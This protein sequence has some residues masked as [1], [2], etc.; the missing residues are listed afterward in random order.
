MK[1]PPSPVQESAQAM[2]AAGR[3]FHQRGWV[4]AT[5][6]NFSARLGAESMLVTASGWHKGE[7]DQDAFLISDLNG[8]PQDSGRKASYETLLHCQLYRHDPD[9]GSVLHT[10]SIAN[11]VLSRRH[12]SIVLTG[13]ELLKLLPGI[14]THD[15]TVEV[16]VFGNDQD[17][18]RLA[19]TVDQWMKQ[20]AG[21]PGY[22]IAGH[23]LYTW[24]ANVAQARHRVEALEFL[25]ECELHSKSQ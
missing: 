11:T 19:G 16:P 15:A 14:Q 8:R 9:I 22:L 13:Y 10:H 17:I 12:A 3:L 5:G 24:G 23:G 25:F 20:H 7:L 18:A 6:G 4:P 21:V 2:I 1:A